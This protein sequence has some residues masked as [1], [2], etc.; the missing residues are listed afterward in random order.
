MPKLL[1]DAS[2]CNDADELSHLGVLG[3]RRDLGL[4]QRLHDINRGGSLVRDCINSRA[5]RFGLRRFQADGVRH[6][7][8]MWTTTERIRLLNAAAD[9]SPDSDST[10]RQ[11]VSTSSG[12]MRKS[13]KR[14]QRPLAVANLT[15]RK[16]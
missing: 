11:K 2:G 13:H 12:D 16:R 10:W 4:V 6:R 8:E 5:I 3:E 7:R 1:L 15:A 9:D 14:R